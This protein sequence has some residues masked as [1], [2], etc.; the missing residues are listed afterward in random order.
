MDAT[1]WT[2]ARDARAWLDAANGRGDTELTCRIL[3]IG[4]EAGEVAAAW[5]GLLGQNPR[6]GVTHTREEVA[7]ELADVAFTALVAIESLGLD[8]HAVLTACADKVRSRTGA[9]M[10]R[11]A[12]ADV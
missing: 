1:I 9:G 7:A 3:K 11:D 10:N 5:I 4:E 2:T 12:D 8:A 6:K